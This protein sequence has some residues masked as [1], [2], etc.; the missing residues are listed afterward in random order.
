MKTSDFFYD[1]P[2]DLIAQHPME[3]RDESRLMLVNKMTGEVGHKKFYNII[4]TVND[5]NCHLTND[6][7]TPHNS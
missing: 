4:R 1:L 3:N 7:G 6:F 5:R 2:K